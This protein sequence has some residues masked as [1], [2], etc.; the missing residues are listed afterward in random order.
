MLT[1]EIVTNAGGELDR[2]GEAH[3]ALKIAILT[4]LLRNV[5]QT[6]ARL[7][8]QVTALGG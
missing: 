5:H 8:R 7:A 2:L 4:N 6:V 3:P 1:P